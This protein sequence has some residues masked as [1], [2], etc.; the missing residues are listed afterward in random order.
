MLD[1]LS[2]F[3]WLLEAMGA[4]CVFFIGLFVKGH[5][6]RIARMERETDVVERDLSNF[7][8]DAEKRFAKEE[9]MQ[10]SLARI[11]DRLDKLPREI[12]DMMQGAKL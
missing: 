5:N 1:E 4:V 8:L 12:R 2:I 10:T 6:M 9:T 7:K 3:R 11:H